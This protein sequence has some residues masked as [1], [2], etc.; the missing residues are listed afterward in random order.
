MAPLTFV[1][2]KISFRS[3]ILLGIMAAI[4]QIVYIIEPSPPSRL[5]PSLNFFFL[6]LSFILQCR[7]LQLLSARPKCLSSL[8]LLRSLALYWDSFSLILKHAQAYGMSVS[9]WIC[10]CDTN[11]CDID[12][13]P[14]SDSSLSSQNISSGMVTMRSQRLR[15]Q[16]RQ[17]PRPSFDRC[18]PA[19]TALSPKSTSTC[20]NPTVHSTPILTSTALSS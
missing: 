8:D 4:V 12:F 20:T 6:F 2:S 14:R 16:L 10:I 15:L 17:L 18:V 19:L 5:T 11:S 9:P 3:T 13:R 1:E 7:Q